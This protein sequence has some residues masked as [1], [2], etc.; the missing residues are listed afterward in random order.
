MMCFFSSILD[1][2]QLSIRKMQ[3]F[4][5]KQAIE[6]GRRRSEDRGQKTDNRGQMS[7]DR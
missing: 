6:A 5:K 1:T 3:Q 7:E 2:S 4:N